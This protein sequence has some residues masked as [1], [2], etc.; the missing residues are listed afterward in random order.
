MR[1]EVVSYHSRRGKPKAGTD[2]RDLAVLLL[3]FPELKSETGIVSDILRQR[4]IDKKV[5]GVWREIVAQDLQVEDD[6]EDLIF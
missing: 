4:E 2:W 1:A 3:Q 6:D 5:L